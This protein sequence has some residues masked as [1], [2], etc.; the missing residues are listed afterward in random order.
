[1]SRRVFP[2]AGSGSSFGGG[3]AATAA[4]LIAACS[5]SSEQQHCGAI[6]QALYGTDAGVVDERVSQN[7]GVLVIVSR[8]QPSAE[9]CSA[10]RVAPEWL[11]TARHCIP[12]GL[13]WSL[14]ASFARSV[15]EA[16]LNNPASRVCDT[17]GLGRY[18][19]KRV[20]QHS[21][22]DLALLQV[23]DSTRSWI[24]RATQ[25]PIIG[26]TVTMVGYGLQET[27]TV[28]VREELSARV[29]GLND[30]LIE[31]R[32]DDG[33]AC[34]GDS[35]GPLIRSTVDGPEL[36][37]VL[38]RGSADCKTHDRY[39]SIAEATSWLED[40]IASAAD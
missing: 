1:M 12:T 24:A 32:A 14:F 34:A 2:I 9:V 20:E 37:G 3:I 4:C 27:G 6:V 16:S 7:V 26:E 38:S 22:S 5:A 13:E 30:A 11:L 28:G 21:I 29:T 25:P 8:D 19:V 40:T 17:G 23:S 18:H 10:T 31:V 36:L 33:G 35:G 39:V 15:S